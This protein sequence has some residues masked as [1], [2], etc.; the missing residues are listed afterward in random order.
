MNS[1]KFLGLDLR[2]S[3]FEAKKHTSFLGLLP[4]AAL[5]ALVVVSGVVQ[6]R[7]TMA[8]QQRQN[9]NQPI[10]QQ[11]QTMMKIM[12][13]LNLMTVGFPSGVAL[14]WLTRNVW[15]IGQQHFVLGKFYEDLGAAPGSDPKV[16]PPVSALEAAQS[17]PTTNRNTSK[18]KQ[19]QQRRRH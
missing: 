3:L 2:Y 8:R 15:T 4:Y 7:Q 9:P 18:K 10:N 13:L 6:M 5:V 19:Q 1:R 16:K 17:P 14:Y 12:P 11:Q